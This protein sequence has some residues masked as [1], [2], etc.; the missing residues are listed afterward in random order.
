MTTRENGVIPSLGEIVQIGQSLG[1]LPGDDGTITGGKDH[2]L[3]RI[4]VASRRIVDSTV[5][6]GNGSLTD[7]VRNYTP[8]DQAWIYW[9]ETLHGI[10]VRYGRYLPYPPLNGVPIPTLEEP[11]NPYGIGPKWLNILSRFAH[12]LLEFNPHSNHLRDTGTHQTGHSPPND[13]ATQLAN[14][15]TYQLGRAVVGVAYN[16]VKGWMRMDA[17]KLA[18]N[19]SLVS[20]IDNWEIWRDGRIPNHPNEIPIPNLNSMMQMI[21][22]DAVTEVAGLCVGAWVYQLNTRIASSSY[23][24]NLNSSGEI[25]LPDT[26][27]TTWYPNLFLH[28]VTGTNS[29]QSDQWD[30]IMSWFREAHDHYLENVA[31]AIEH[32]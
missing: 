31:P 17:E 21:C 20:D 6:G 1:T 16:R 22:G 9:G 5:I 14:K 26:S 8:P 24:T 30:E 29:Q 11:V 28:R 10:N 19:P 32:T 12:D 3:A 25:R 15:V 4:E 27:S 18:L 23:N 13:A 7:A 2:Q